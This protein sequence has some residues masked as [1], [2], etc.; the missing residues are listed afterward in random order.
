M[1]LSARNQPRATVVDVKLGEVMSTMRVNLQRL[2]ARH[3]QLGLMAREILDEVS[4]ALRP[5]GSDQ[6]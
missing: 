5:C 1:K 3:G 6:R 4:L 2:G